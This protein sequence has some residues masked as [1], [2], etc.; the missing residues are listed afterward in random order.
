M[1][2][3]LYVDPIETRKAG[4][5]TFDEI[6]VNVYNKSIKDERKKYGDDALIGIYHD[7]TVLREFE[8]MLNQIKTQGLYNG[9]ETTYPGPAH[10]SIGQEASAVGQAYCLDINDFTFGSHRSHGEIIAKGLSSIYKLDEDELYEIMEEFLGGSILSV[11]EKKHEKKGDIR[12]LA[13]DFLLY[14]ALAE[15]FARTTGFNRGLGGSMHA[16]FIPFGIMPNNAIVGS[17]AP[18][19]LGAACGG[20]WG[21]AVLGTVFGLTSFLQAFGIG[22]L[23]DPMAAGLFNENPFYYTVTCFVPRIA[24]GMLSGLVIFLF[25][26]TKKMSV[27]KFALAAIV[28]PVV[29]T[30]GFLGFYMTFYS[31]TAF[32][33]ELIMAVITAALTLNFLVEFIVT[34]VAS[35]AINRT[36]YAF[37]KKME[38]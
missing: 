10:L 20:I 14:G 7:I 15:I 23:I 17:A 16:F 32:G 4:K 38:H 6:P 21:G 36:V 33:T 26:K 22:F 28:V 13:I 3:S 11:V 35:T 5:I 18:V 19:A 27:W 1:P 34:L 31:G 37:T 25:E 12:D 29:N 24:A 9:I 2:K 8:S 30:F